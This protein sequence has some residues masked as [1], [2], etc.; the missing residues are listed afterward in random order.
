MG[1]RWLPAAVALS[2]AACGPDTAPGSPE[3]VTLRVLTW[4]G[5]QEVTTEQRIADLFAERHPGVHVVVESTPAN[6]QEKLLTAIA[7]GAPPDVFLLDGPD[8]PSFLDRGL[9]LDLTPYLPPLGYDRSRVF[10][11]VRET[12]ERGGRLYAFPKDFTPMV[13]YANRSV[14]RRWGAELPAPGADWTWD[15]FLAAARTLTRDT[16]GDG[17]V[18]LYAFDFPRNPYQWIPWVW[19]GGGDILG[20]D[21][22]R[23]TGYLDSPATV[24]SFRFLTGLVTDAKVTPGVQFVAAGDP[25]REARFATGGQAMLFSGHWTLQ[26]LVSGMGVDPASLAILPIPHRRGVDPVTVLYASGWAV[27]AN[28]VHRRRALELAAFLASEEAQRVRASTRLAIPSFQDVAEELAAADTTG[29]EAAFLQQAALGRM[30]WGARVRDFNEVE[31]LVFR[32]MDRH[33]LRGEP[34]DA[35]ATDIARQVDEVLRR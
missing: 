9:T 29:V 15:A 23:A 25:A 10:D 34:L 5:D 24:E 26:L 6:Y 32:V 35:A 33:L 28:V 30:T 8:I 20:P 27:P 3:T 2:I 11:E 1:F 17:R 18:D 13:I 4:A 31:E 7:A 16:T 14:F 22:T 19:A 12:F 21:G